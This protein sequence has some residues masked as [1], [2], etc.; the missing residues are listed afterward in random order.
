M[1]VA[2]IDHEFV[3]GEIEARR[4]LETQFR[5]VLADMEVWSQWGST[6]NLSPTTTGGNEKSHG[7][8]AGAL[9]EAEKPPHEVW[10]GRWLVAA[11]KEKLFK[12]ATEELQ[13]LRYGPPIEN[14]PEIKPETM[15]ELHTRIVH[16]G[17]GWS[18]EQVEW[19]FKASSKIIR[20]ARRKAGVTADY[21]RT[22][23]I[24]KA[25]DKREY[26]QQL[27]ETGYTEEQIAMITGIPRTS[28]RRAIGRESSKTP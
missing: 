1:G 22:R 5:Q 15:E 14:R 28:L 25:K 6:S 8:P 11:N 2:V 27:A 4:K 26:A 12:E 17:A 13:L 18:V 3:V 9:K 24:L 19:T 21:G 10:R 20:E 16:E 7:R 23:K